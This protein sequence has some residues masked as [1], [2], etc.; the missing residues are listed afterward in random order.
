MWPNLVKIKGPS[1]NLLIFP[2]GALP[3][4]YTTTKVATTQDISEKPSIIGR[5][6]G[7]CQNFRNPR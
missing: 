6:A 2:N 1:Y 7:R 5:I 4:M 3:S